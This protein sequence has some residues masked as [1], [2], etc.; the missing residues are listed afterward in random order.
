MSVQSRLNTPV[1]IVGMACRL[2]GADNLDQF[3]QM[4]RSGRTALGPAPADRFD[5]ELLYDPRKGVFGK[6]YTDL[7]GVVSYGPIDRDLYPISDATLASHDIAHVTLC[8]VV[9]DACR[10]ASFDPMAL[11]HRN[12]GVYVGH[13]RPS[14]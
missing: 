4:L 13:T 8:Q 7:A 5:R 10:H 6:S 1:A 11:P 9:M 2:P 3:W 12:T 14:G